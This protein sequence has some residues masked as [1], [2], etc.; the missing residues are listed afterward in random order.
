MDQS[1]SLESLK[2]DLEKQKEI[3]INNLLSDNK[4]EYFDESDEKILFD[5]EDEWC[6]LDDSLNLVNNKI[7]TTLTSEIS[8]KKISDITG[9]IPEYENLTIYKIVEKSE[10]KHY[11]V[12]NKVHNGII[13]VLSNIIKNNKGESCVNICIEK[14]LFDIFSNYQNI[15]NIDELVINNELIEKYNLYIEVCYNEC[16]RI[17]NELMPAMIENQIN[18][19]K[20][21]IGKMLDIYIKKDQRIKLMDILLE[22]YPNLTNNKVIKNWIDPEKNKMDNP[23]NEIENICIL[24]I[25]NNICKFSK[26]KYP[27]LAQFFNKFYELETPIV[28]S[29]GFITDNIKLLNEDGYDFSNKID[30]VTFIVVWIDEIFRNNSS[31]KRKLYFI[32]KLISKSFNKYSNKRS[33]LDRIFTR[34][35]KIDKKYCDLIKANIVKI[36]E[37]DRIVMGQYQDI[38]ED[39][40]VIC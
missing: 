2:N 31:M 32:H 35:I 5:I 23:F 15:I 24:W 18:N 28:I 8:I 36:Y 40:C 14:N 22:K 11:I 26:E 33:I 1:T 37:N 34:Y 16:Q 6:N 19:N 9:I 10:K 39:S 29:F 12:L 13:Y 3:D 27:F 4:V 17:M 7:S 21:Y 25:E 30:G 20:I 38:N